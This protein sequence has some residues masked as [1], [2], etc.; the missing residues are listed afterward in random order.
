M[1]LEGHTQ[2]VRAICWNYEIPYV[3]LSGSWDSTIKVWDIRSGEMIDTID[4]HVGD[5]YG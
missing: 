3:L 5:I 2:P 4:N 1:T